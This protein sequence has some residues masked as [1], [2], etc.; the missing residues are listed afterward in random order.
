VAAP[1]ANGLL[2]LANERKIVDDV[3]K[4]LMTLQARFS[5]RVSGPCSGIR[6]HSL[7]DAPDQ[8]EIFIKHAH[9]DSTA[10]PS[11]P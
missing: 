10:H 6:P 7:Q 4:D 11:A 9:A 5:V 3:H 2:E 1:Y 8:Q